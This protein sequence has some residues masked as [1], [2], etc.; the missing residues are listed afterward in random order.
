MDSEN[1]DSDIPNILAEIINF[2]F[3]FVARK[4]TRKLYEQQ[5]NLFET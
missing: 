4:K 1:S 3:R 2:N 5:Y